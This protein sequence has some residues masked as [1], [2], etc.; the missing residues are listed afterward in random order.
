[1]VKVDG[2]KVGKLADTPAPSDIPLKNGTWDSGLF[3]LIFK[4]GN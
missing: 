4:W 3:G 1:V 2:T